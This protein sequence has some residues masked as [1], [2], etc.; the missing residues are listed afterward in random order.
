[1]TPRKALTNAAE[2]CKLR[3]VRRTRV[4][5]KLRQATVEGDA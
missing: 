2:V 1:M 3:Q 5:C 4:V